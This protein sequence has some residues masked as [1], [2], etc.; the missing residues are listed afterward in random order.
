MYSEYPATPLPIRSDEEMAQRLADEI[1]ERLLFE[2]A[3]D[4][5]T[6][7]MGVREATVV[8]R[9]QYLVAR[10]EAKMEAEFKLR[11]AFGLNRMS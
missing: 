2:N 6:T 7:D 1:V 10:A 3:D 9:V 11:N 8:A 5:D 4:V